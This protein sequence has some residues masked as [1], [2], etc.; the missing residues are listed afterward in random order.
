MRFLKAIELNN[1]VCYD[2][3]RFPLDRHG[4]TVVYGRNKDSGLDDAKSNGAGKSLPF[5]MLAETLMDQNPVLEGRHVVKESFFRKDAQSSVEFDDY[6]VEKSIKGKTPQYAM[7]KAVGEEWK[8]SK[9][10]TTAY[11]KAKLGELMP[12][13]VDEFFTLYYIDSNR[14]SD[15]QRGSHSDRLALF[16]KL[17]NLSKYDLIQGE[18]KERLKAMRKLDQELTTVLNQIAV[19]EPQIP[20]DLAD[21]LA[22]LETKQSKQRKLNERRAEAN[23]LLNLATTYNAHRRSLTEL[24][25]FWLRLAEKSKEEGRLQGLRGEMPQPDWLDREFL[26]EF[27]SA[28]NEGYANLKKEVARGYAQQAAQHKLADTRERVAKLTK[29]VKGWTTQKVKAALAEAREHADL[30]SDHKAELKEIQRHLDKLTV[31]DEPEGGYDSTRIAVKKAYPDIKLVQL[32]PHAKSELN[33]AQAIYDMAVRAENNFK[34]KFTDGSAC[35]CPTCHGSLDEATIQSIADNLHEVTRIKLALLG[36]EKQQFDQVHQLVSWMD[37]NRELAQLTNR[38]NELAE[39]EAYDGPSADELADL[40]Q[41][42]ADLA[43]EQQELTELE[44]AAVGEPVDHEALSDSMMAIKNA[45]FNAEAVLAAHRVLADADKEQAGEYDIEELTEGLDKVDQTLTRLMKDVPALAQYVALGQSK[46]RELKALTNRKKDLE[47]DLF[48]MPILKVFDEAYGQKGLKNLAIQR[49][50]NIIETNLNTNKSLLL[51][52][53]MR[54]E[55]IVSETE[56]HILAHREYQ[57]EKSDADIRRF[58]GAESRA[59]NMLL[60]MSILPLIP[61]DRRL[62]IMALDEPTANLDPP[63]IELFVD[64]FLPKLLELVPHVIVLSPDKLQLDIDAEVWCATREKGRSV[65]EKEG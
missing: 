18:V 45:R 48:D 26:T 58:S 31:V 6:R 35:K 43:R 8:P 50:C 9:V 32:L 25:D 7:Y 41:A 51:A 12:I 34:A 52:E 29:R 11:A 14:Q 33:G 46:Q 10:R 15:L 5:I 16:S 61:G 54:F 17:F 27:I 28:A 13:G 64:K 2:Q 63:A 21:K 53:Q 42:L 19:I 37:Y 4:L 57:G 20:D 59:I 22:D 65:L 30:M 3:L 24:H 49:V 36:A 38:R 60:A 44:E 40:R 56:M 62:N 47:L 23:R 39:P 55:I 1:I